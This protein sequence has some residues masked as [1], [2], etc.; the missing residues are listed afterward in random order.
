MDRVRAGDLNAKGAKGANVA[1]GERRRAELG[2]LARVTD[3]SYGV[4]RRSFDVTSHSYGVTRRSFDVTSHPYDVT[5]HPY[6]VTSHPYGVTSH[7]S[8]RMC[9]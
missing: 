6:D 7:P 2:G 4:T 5:S 1:K 8:P 3:G 9:C